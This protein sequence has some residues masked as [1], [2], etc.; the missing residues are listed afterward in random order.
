MNTPK[1]TTSALAG[2]GRSTKVYSGRTHAEKLVYYEL[3][4]TKE[5]LHKEAMRVRQIV[6]LPQPLLPQSLRPQTYSHTSS[7]WAPLGDM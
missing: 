3:T 4:I 1:P 2:G 5:R 7:I 6:L